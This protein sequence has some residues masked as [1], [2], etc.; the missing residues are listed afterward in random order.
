MEWLG[1]FADV[2]GIFGAVFALF[3][4]RQARQVRQELESEKNRQNKKVTVVLQCG[5]DRLELPIEL[6]RVELTRAEV[7]GRIGML[8]MKVKGQRF[9]LDYVSTIEFARQISQIIEGEG[10]ALLTIPCEKQELDQF[11]VTR[12]R[13]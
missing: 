2:I 6:R 12:R 8:P 3:G 7:L 4:W 5:A 10:D 11:D 1:Y 13:A 9:S